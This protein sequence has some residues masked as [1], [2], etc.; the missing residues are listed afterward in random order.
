MRDY[1]GDEPTGAVAIERRQGRKLDTL[2]ASTE[3]KRRL[4]I[5]ID[6]GGTDIKAGL[7]DEDGNVLAVR[8]IPTKTESGVN[9]VLSRFADL[10]KE[11]ETDMPEAGELIGIGLGIPGSIDLHSNRV[12]ACA[13][14]E[15]WENRDIAGELG[16]LLG[17][18]VLIENDANLAAY[19]EYLHGAGQNV[20]SMMTLTLGTG[21]GGGTILNGKIW[22]GADGTAS[23]VGHMIVTSDGRLCGCGQRGCLETYAS[24]SSIARIAEERLQSGTES[25]LR[26][27]QNSGGG[28]T[29]K[30][31]A[32]HAANGDNVAL[33]VWNEACRHLAE[34]IVGLQHV[35]NPGRII[36]AGG[37]SA[38]G[39]I[40]LDTVRRFVAQLMPGKV[41]TH[42]DVQL[43]QLGN[44]A[45]FLGA[46]LLVFNEC[47]AKVEVS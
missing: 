44:D 2:N 42:P 20:A 28:I 9:G 37:M 11:L 26:A 47:D 19:A 39:P 29:S 41:G 6:L 16:A 40:L 35:I 43:A 32:E 23:E 8:R 18:P 27:V 24:A 12:R 31:I 34:A 30:I 45:G 13:N 5:G 3:P 17:R 33:D 15:G 1:R 22:R 36:L 46:A 38:A 4:A 25:S 21:V 10:V 7:V 14:L